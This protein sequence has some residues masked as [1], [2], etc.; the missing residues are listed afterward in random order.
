[1]T[2]RV[3]ASPDQRSG[4]GHLIKNFFFK[5]T[6]F[7]IGFCLLTG[8]IATREDMASL[9]V[10]IARLENNIGQLEKRQ[11]ELAA[12]LSEVKRPVETLQSSLSDTQQLFNNF[13]PRF[14]EL[15]AILESLKQDFAEKVLG[16]E[17]RL[18]Q[19]IQ[20]AKKTIE[21]TQTPT[22]RSSGPTEIYQKAYQDFQAKKWDLAETGFSLYMKNYPDGAFSDESLF[23]WGLLEKEKKDYPKAQELIEK[24][25][26]DHPKSALVKSALLAKAEI[27]LAENRAKEAEG[28]LELITVKYPQ[29]KEA[30]RAQELLSGLGKQ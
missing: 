28:L 21:K 10:Q 20:D 8:C 13:N 19:K 26:K 3:M 16:L 24:L 2:R 5:N 18:G 27:L 1:M 30:N 9:E 12:S 6:V 17:N 22:S 4:R 11:A 29:S 15:R 25:T 7:V 23:Y 14:E